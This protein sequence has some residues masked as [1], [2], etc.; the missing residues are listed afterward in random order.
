MALPAAAGGAR[1][2]AEDAS[3]REGPAVAA[4]VDGDVARER[5][6][7]P[8]G[9]RGAAELPAAHGVDRDP[10]L[11]EQDRV[12]GLVDLDGIRHHDS[13]AGG[14]FVGE[15]AVVALEP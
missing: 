1:L 12:H 2:P 5:A 8:A 3:G 10:P 7:G 15:P 4:V 14:G 13:V 9:R 6:I 11:L